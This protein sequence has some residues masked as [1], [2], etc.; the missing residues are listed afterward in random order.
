VL[1]ED[2]EL[3]SRISEEA[4]VRQD[5]PEPRELRL[6][7]AL[8]QELCLVDQLGKARNL[9]TERSRID[10]R[11]HVFK[12]GDNI[13]LLFLGEVVEVVGELPIDL[14]PPFSGTSRSNPPAN[15]CR[16]AASLAPFLR[17]PR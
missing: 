11:D 2:Q 15:K 4:I 16:L 1:T 7:L 6:D 17:L 9:L 12:L 13:L 8:L 5:V 10:R 3:F 14:I